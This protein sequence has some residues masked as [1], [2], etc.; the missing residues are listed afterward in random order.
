METSL[1]N[2]IA[3][4]QLLEIISKKKLKKKYHMQ[5]RHAEDISRNK[6]IFASLLFKIENDATEA[7][8]DHLL[9]LLGVIKLMCGPNGFGIAP[10]M[11]EDK[12]IKDRLLRFCRKELKPHNYFVRSLSSGFSDGWGLLLLLSNHATDKNPLPLGDLNPKD[13]SNNL[14]V[15]FKYASTVFQVPPILKVEN[16]LSFGGVDDSSMLIYLS[17]LLDGIRLSEGLPPAGLSQTSVPISIPNPNSNP[18][19]NPLKASELESSQKSFILSA[20]NSSLIQSNSNCNSHSKSNA[21]VKSSPL[22][23]SA[24]TSAHVNANANEN[25]ENRPAQLPLASTFLK[26]SEDAYKR[27]WR[28]AEMSCSR[29][30]REKSVLQEEVS[31]LK[32]ALQ[33]QEQ[34]RKG[35]RERE[36]QEQLAQKQKDDP[37]EMQEDAQ[38]EDKVKELNLTISLLRKQLSEMERDRAQ[39]NAWVDKQK[40]MNFSL[41]L[42]KDEI[43]SKDSELQMSKKM[44]EDLSVNL[45]KYQE[46]VD[47]A[48]RKFRQ[49]EKEKIELTRHFH[50]KLDTLISEN[51]TLRKQG[52]SFQEESQT[53]LQQWQA[54][55][56]ENR[57]LAQLIQELRDENAKITLEK[58]SLQ[59]ALS[60]MEQSMTEKLDRAE[61]EKSTIRRELEEATLK[62][63]EE[64]QSATK[65]TEQITAEKSTMEKELDALYAQVKVENNHAAND[66][67]DDSEKTPSTAIHVRDPL[68]EGGWCSFT[69]ESIAS[70]QQLR[71]PAV[72]HDHC[73]NDNN[74]D[75]E[76]NNNHLS[77][78]SSRRQMLSDCS[79]AL[80]V[81]SASSPATTPRD[82][83]LTPRLPS[84]SV[85]NGDTVSSCIAIGAH[86]SPQLCKSWLATPE[87]CASTFYGR[88]PSVGRANSEG[89]SWSECPST[90]SDSSC[91]TTTDFSVIGYNHPLPVGLNALFTKGL[92]GMFFSAVQE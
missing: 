39:E 49:A 47:D 65:Y 62:F 82:T 59:E 50:M 53:R 3:P 26:D 9:F 36:R 46:A 14:T 42:L 43:S 24:L 19:S 91:S 52:A 61:V 33:E 66:S 54:L 29:L 20:S 40:E 83:L 92:G 25:M 18:I 45:Q 67:T 2:F 4:I 48:N 17:L 73:H 86:P 7:A 68:N 12:S 41:S 31:A 15:A 56:L 70:S 23:L 89:R 30:Q 21:G 16:F 5:P 6:Q 75:N 38:L 22:T 32:E 28:A 69:P 51:K 64:L 81:L 13:A 58:T 27:K 80:S 78:A 79:L 90:V 37:K 8:N 63:E 76:N 34:K 74:N 72:P 85:E 44:E 87:S 84:T 11:A 57:N 1:K 71:L 10:D 60:G 55:S 88:S 77:E 35:E